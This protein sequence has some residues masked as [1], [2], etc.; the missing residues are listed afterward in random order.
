LDKK[1]KLQ[2]AENIQLPLF[3]KTSDFTK[4]KAHIEGFAPE[5]FLVN[6]IGNEVLSD[7][8]IVRPTSEVIFSQLFK[9]LVHSYNDLPIKYN[10]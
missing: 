7:P 6:K 3:I 10:Q 5:A 9:E 4:E 8:L 1:L 2:G